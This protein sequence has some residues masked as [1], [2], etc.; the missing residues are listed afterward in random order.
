VTAADTRV[1]AVAQEEPGLVRHVW[2]A[3]NQPA[4][5]L[6]GNLT[7]SME[8]GRGGAVAF[9]FA[10]G[11]TVRAE[12]LS[13]Y[14]SSDRTGSGAATFQSLLALPDQVRARVYRVIDQVTTRSARNGGLCGAEQRPTALAAAEFVDADGDWVLRVAAFRGA[15]PPGGAADPELCNAFAFQQPR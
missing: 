7:V 4:R 10:N 14:E 6:T 3:A 1:D 5:E 15:E 2:R 8:E 11:I 13:V 9:A 12:E